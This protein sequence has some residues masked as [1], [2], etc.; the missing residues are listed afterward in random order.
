M[1]LTEAPPDA[2]ARVY[3]ESIF[4]L[5]HKDGGQSG[6]EATLGEL[7]DVLEIARSETRFSEFL[8]SRILPVEARGAALRRIFAERASKL[9]LNFLLVLNAKGR[10]GHLA[11]IVAA[12]DEKVQAAFG[13]VEV[14][15]YTAS[16][17]SGEELNAIR[18]RLREKL[19]REPIV[20]PYVDS[21]MIGGLKLQIGDQLIDASIAARLS[22]LRDRLAGEGSAKVR[23]RADRLFDES[24]ASTN[25]HPLT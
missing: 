20:H 23:A 8:S 10:L 12:L 13:R 14:D 11:P 15:L 19:G 21:D 9:T 25:G 16:P 6:V 18:D 24:G 2:L 3:A 1:P 22:K 17:I 4:E 7:E 5:A